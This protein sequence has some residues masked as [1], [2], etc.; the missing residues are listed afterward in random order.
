MSERFADSANE[1]TVP[2]Y[3]RVDA[4]ASYETAGGQVIDFSVDNLFDTG[5]IQSG[6][7][8]AWNYGN[9]RRVWLMFRQSF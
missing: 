4:G 7:T 2:G 5:Y 8:N 9:F 1:I 6:F 3:V